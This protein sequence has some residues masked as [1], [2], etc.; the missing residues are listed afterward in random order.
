MLGKKQLQ[1]EH[2]YQTP[3]E[4]LLCELL[5]WAAAWKEQWHC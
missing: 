4:Y 2:Q 5:A 1:G 3:A